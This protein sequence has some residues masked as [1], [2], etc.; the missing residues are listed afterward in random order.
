MKRFLALLVPAVLMLG[1]C[2][3]LK[4]PHVP[5][6]DVDLT[7]PLLNER[8]LVSELADSVHIVVGDGD[9]LTLTGTGSAE[10]PPF[11][12]VNFTPEIDLQGIALEAGT[13]ITM[14]VPIMDPTGSVYPCYGRLE[15]GMIRYMFALDNPGTS[16]VSLTL[17]NLYTP[18]GTPFQIIS[19][20]SPNWQSANLEGCFF[21][22]ENSGIIM[23]TLSFTFTV[24]SDQPFGTQIGT[25]GLRIDSQLGFDKFQGYLY[26][27]V[28]AL[29]GTI[30]SINIDYPLDLEQ[31]VQLQQASV[32]LLVTNEFGFGAEFHG[33]L[34]ATNNR[35]G[36]TRLIELLDDQGNPYM[37]QPASFDGPALTEIIVSNNVSD[38]LQIMPDAIEIFDSYLLIN[39][40]HDGV[41]GF[42]EEDNKLYCTYQVDAPFQFILYDHEFQMSEAQSVE[43]P[44]DVRDQVLE[45]VLEAA[46]TLG[47]TNKIPVGF[48][49]NVFASATPEIDVLDPATYA[50][51][52]TINIHSSQYE[53][54]DVNEQGEQTL[55]LALNEAELDVFANQMVYMLMSFSFEPSNG[56]VTIYASPADYIQV[57]SMLT[58]R[59]HVE[60]D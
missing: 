50:F 22:E 39:G 31:A 24:Q 60:V 57:K 19:N 53:G 1:A 34:K 33:T 32:R 15:Q 25:M 16:S 36:E 13:Q 46:L 56:P 55:Q 4:K 43:I 6:W 40:G 20:G 27:Y 54:P 18:E 21:G 3:I 38:L 58:A 48:T 52:K 47:I 51:K 7:V 17:N 41:P 49:A 14:T 10:T 9:V 59:V 30:T 28:R 44:S 8:W 42:V 23:D 35:T 26:N 11:G 12:E 37:V 2:D 45:R 5:S 29:E